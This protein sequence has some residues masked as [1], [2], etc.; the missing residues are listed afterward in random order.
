MR[1]NRLAVVFVPFCR[2]FL[3]HWFSFFCSRGKVSQSTL[4]KAVLLGRHHDYQASSQ[5]WFRVFLCF[6]RPTSISLGGFERARGLWHFN[7]L[8]LLN[9]DASF[10]LA[11]HFPRLILV[12]GLQKRFFFLFDKL[13]SCFKCQKEWE[14]FSSSAS[15]KMRNS[16]ES[17]H[18]F[19]WLQMMPLSED[20]ISLLVF[21]FCE[22]LRLF[23]AS[24]SS[25]F[26][27]EP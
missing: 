22:E 17:Q 15:R 23:K 16:A 7:F 18:L 24:F 26:S 2:Q 11:F 14:G 12:S 6:L 19:E 27:L 1:G 25:L 10:L 9:D 20:S 8:L 4:V 5:L 21:S 13:R 3:L